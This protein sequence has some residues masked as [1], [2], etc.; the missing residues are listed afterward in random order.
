MPRNV[1]NTLMPIL[2]LA[3]VLMLVPVGVSADPEICNYLDD[4]DGLIDEDFDYMGIPVG[5]GCD[6]VGE[7]GLGAVYCVDE[8]TADCST[9]PGR[10]EYDGGAEVCDY[11]DNDCDGTIDNG[12]DYL[13]T[14]VGG[15]C[16]GIGECGFGSVY[17]SSTTTADCSTNPGGPSDQSEAE[18]CNGLDD[19]CDGDVDDGL[20]CLPGDANGDCIV[21]IFDLAIVG[22][23]YG[24]HPGDPYWDV[25][26][27]V[28][29]D[30]VIGILDLATV[31]INYRSTCA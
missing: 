25:R 31:G 19:D 8:N 17:C 22:R 3:L 21:N 14:P 15:G 2:V 16:D 13:G 18:T 7:C 4:D 11:K 6:G 24:T 30:G 20:V 1:L 28:N 9:N 27:D 26:A 12:F 23:A 29:W 5:G 10:P